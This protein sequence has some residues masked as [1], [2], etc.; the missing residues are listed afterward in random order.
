MENHPREKKYED[1]MNK[2]I[3][4]ENIRNEKF[5]KILSLR[6]V[7]RSKDN[8]ANIRDKINLLYEPKYKICINHLK[9]NNDDIR[10]FNINIHEPEK[11][12]DKLKYLLNSSDDDELKFGL[13]ALKVYYKYL[14]KEVNNKQGENNK[15]KNTVNNM[16]INE[17]TQTFVIDKDELKKR[18][19]NDTELF[20]E[21]DIINLLFEI[22]NKSLNKN[23]NKYISNIYECLCIIINM[24]AI[25]PCEED[26]KIEFFKSLAQGGNLNTLLYMLKDPNM[27][28]EILFNILILFGNITID[29][30][31]I[32]R[33]L[34]INSS[35]T[36]ILFNYLKTSKKLNSEVFLKIYRVLHFL[37]TNCFN[38]NVEAYKIIFKIFSLPLYKFR[39]NELTQYCLEVLLMLSHI[40][41]KEIENCFNDL[42]LMGVLNDI[43]FSKNIEGNIYNIDLILDIFTNIIEKDN[44]DLQKNIVNSG[45][46]YIFYNNLL[47]KYKKEKIIIDY[48][49]ETNLF[50]AL[51]N[52]LVFNYEDM[53]KYILTE[54]KEILNF[55][56]ESARSVFLET[57]KFGICLLHNV[58]ISNQNQISIQILYDIT[59]IVLDTLNIN[60]FSK[61]F[62]L[63]IECIYLLILKSE[64]MNFSNE[65]KACFIQKGLSNC[66]DR[67]ETMILNDSHIE[68]K[69]EENYL[70]IIDAIKNFI[71]N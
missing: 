4:L 69:D 5:E 68:K 7:K 57:R 32:I 16:M 37:Y 19:I 53:V 9:T 2:G 11:S 20:I 22:I 50:I 21:N 55:F 13:Y 62:L 34:L 59:N 43:I 29:N 48:K 40:K 41:E 47:V 42:N 65:L 45:K 54:G 12:M 36:Q 49:A 46:M 38:L 6:K 39:I 35:L 66:C 52:L 44:I 23:E 51:N 25:P 64:N 61:C 24:T 30:V 60:E 17:E 70:D 27:P 31:Q 10:N 63:C 8:I 28:Q 58:L 26:K 3:S 71:N 14:S 15:E 56:M 67:I 18:K 33:D 1:R